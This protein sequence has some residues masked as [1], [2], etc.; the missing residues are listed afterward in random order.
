[1]VSKCS[2]NFFFRFFLH[3]SKKSS[4]FAG[5]FVRAHGCAHLQSRVFIKE[6]TNVPDRMNWRQYILLI[7]LLCAMPLF[8][9]KNAPAKKEKPFTVVIDAGHGGHDPGALGKITQEKKLN[10][11]VSLLLGRMIEEEFPDVRVCYTRKTDVFLTLQERA[12]FVNKNGADIFICIHTNASESRD[13]VGAET[14][15]LGIDKMA[16][17]LNVAM[18]ENAVMLLEDNYETTYQGFDP[19]SI[20]S[21]IM[22]E[23]MQDQYFDQSLQFATLVQQQFSGNLKRADRGVR[24][25]GFWVLHKS[26]CPSVLVEMGFISNTEEEIYLASIAG[27]E[28]VATALYNAFVTYK[29]QIDKKNDLRAVPKQL[30]QFKQPSKSQPEEKSEEK[31]EVNTELKDSVVVISVDTITAKA[32]TTRV[33]PPAAKTQKPVSAPA[34]VS[35]P[36]YRVQIFASS[37][38]L[39]AG[40]A[41]F[42]GLKNC[43]YTRDGNFYKYTYGE[44]ADYVKAV[45]L[46]KQIKAKFPDCFVVAF[47]DGKQIPVKEAR[48]M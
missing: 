24:Q 48:K 11:D 40:D 1:M 46:Q 44:C 7:A 19:N 20:E 27:K 39:K 13:A 34:K 10:L 30:K 45:E 41:S 15:V 22:F 25:A 2:N 43:K 37:R 16:S 32:D 42:K 21:Y 14:F 29:N 38:V 3:M 28:Q 12:D 33:V 4:T 6:T 35:K 23:L 8:A 9:Q 18:R 31:A 5:C 17:N 36:V 47:I 26:A